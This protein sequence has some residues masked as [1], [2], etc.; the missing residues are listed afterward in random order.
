MFCKKAS[1]LPFNKERK[2]K[3]DNELERGKYKRSMIF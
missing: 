3:N 1:V 2:K